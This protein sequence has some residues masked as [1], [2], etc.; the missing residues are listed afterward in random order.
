MY[1]SFT[2]PEELRKYCESLFEFRKITVNKFKWVNKIWSNFIEL[3]FQQHELYLKFEK[4][5]L[6]KARVNTWFKAYLESESLCQCQCDVNFFRTWKDRRRHLNNVKKQSRP[7]LVSIP[8]QQLQV[9]HST[10]NIAVTQF[11]YQIRVLPAYNVTRVAFF[12]PSNTKLI[13]C[14][15]PT[16]KGDHKPRKKGKS[17]VNCQNFYLTW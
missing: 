4:L 5:N 3:D 2:E 11:V 6:V 1:V 14:K 17:M 8:R 12:Q 13:T 10:N 15:V 9:I 16:D 7:A